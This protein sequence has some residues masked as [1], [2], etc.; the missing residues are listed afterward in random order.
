M[1][2]SQEEYAKGLNVG[3]NL[4]L[5]FEFTFETLHNKSLN[6]LKV[7]RQRIFKPSNET[8]ESTEGHQINGRA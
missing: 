5:N 8:F 1:L 3:W 4:Q 2:N 6:E 7:R